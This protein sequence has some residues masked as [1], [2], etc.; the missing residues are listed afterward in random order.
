MHVLVEQLKWSSC[1]A[2]N[3][4]PMKIIRDSPGVGFLGAEDRDGIRNDGECAKGNFTLP[5][6]ERMQEVQIT[7]KDQVDRPTVIDGD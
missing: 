5:S 4:G 7:L 2:K 3:H 1:D 6:G